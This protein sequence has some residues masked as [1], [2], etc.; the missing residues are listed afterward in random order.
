MSRIDFAA[1]IED[2]FFVSHA[3][4]VGVFQNQNAVT[5][6]SLCIVAVGEASIVDDFANPD[7]SEMIDV[8][9]RWAEQH[10]FGCEQLHFNSVSYIKSGDSVF[11]RSIDRRR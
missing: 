1:L 9:V 10:R 2:S 5:F 11:R 4:V 7:T 3:V 6:D 8:D